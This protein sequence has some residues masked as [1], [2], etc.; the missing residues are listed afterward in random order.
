MVGIQELFRFSTRFPMRHGA[1][2]RAAERWDKRNFWFSQPN[3][4]NQQNQDF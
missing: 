3:Q 4:P 2:R 1:L